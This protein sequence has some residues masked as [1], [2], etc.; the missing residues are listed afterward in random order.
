MREERLLAARKLLMSVGGDALLI[1]G[2][3]NISYF[4]GFTGSDGALLISAD[5]NWLLCDGRYTTQA[6]EE[7]PSCRVVEYKV[8]C[9]AIASLVVEQG[10]KRL[11]F[12]GEKVSFALYRSL[13]AALSMVE[14]LPLTRELDELRA[15]KSD[16]ELEVIGQSCA[17]ASAAFLQVVPLIRPGVSERT[18]A[19]ELEI[20]IKRHG[21]EEKAFD[22]IVASGP[23]GALPHGHPT[24]RTLSAGELVTIDFG[25]RLRGYHS[26][27]TVTV[28]VGS[29]D[30]RQREI[31][32]VVREAHDLAMATVR[33]GAAC[34][35]VDAVARDHIAGSGF[36]DFFGHGLGHGVGLEIHEKPTLSPRSEQLLAE[37]MVVTVEPGIYI[38]GWGGVRIEDTVLVTA[39][40]CRPLTQ[41]PKELMVVG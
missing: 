26:D 40:G 28:A 22:F 2:L 4:T 13:S 6:T 7:A 29:A 31:Y 14:L 33:P 8:K 21:A 24:D 19:L 18:L 5:G 17:L 27:E 41:V 37:G 39:D 9:D 12:D 11:A 15:V 34:R 30:S 10:W 32:T 3:I 35:D 38:P 16:P 20:L 23:R 25:A 1:L 36:A